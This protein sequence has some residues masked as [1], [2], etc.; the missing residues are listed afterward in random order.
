[1]TS[2]DVIRKAPTTEK[3]ETFGFQPSLL[4]AVIFLSP[5][6]WYAPL[7]GESQLPYF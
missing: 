3:A 6:E 5:P 2:S 4:L 1:M 7:C